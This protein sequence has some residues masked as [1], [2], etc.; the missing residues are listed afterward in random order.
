MIFNIDI[1]HLKLQ[2]LKVKVQSS[3][4][5]RDDVDSSLEAEELTYSKTTIKTSTSTQ[6]HRLIVVDMYLR[7]HGGVLPFSQSTEY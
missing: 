2:I 7:S 3:D 6:N 4:R 5:Y 1:L